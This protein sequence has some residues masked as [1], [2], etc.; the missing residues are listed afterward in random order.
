MSKIVLGKGLEALIP[1]D[2]LP[3]D[4]RNNFKILPL[5]R[6]A[7]NPMQPRR[8]FSEKGLEELAGS[9]KLNG[10]IQPLVVRKS[11]AS[12]TIIA[13]ERRYRAARLAELREVPVIVM[14]DVDDARM[15]EL[16]LV[17]NLQREDLNSL[18]VAEAYRMLI[19]RCGLTQN[20]LSERVGKSRTAVANLLRLLALPDSIK[21][22]IRDGRLSEGH[23]R[24]ILSVESETE[25]LK[26]A[27]QI[28]DQSLSVRLVE[29]EV[30]RKKRGKRLP[31]RKSP[32]I[33]EIE[34]WLKQL[35]GTSVKIHPGLKRGRIE[36]EYYNEDDLGRLVDLFKTIRN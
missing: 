20:Q 29:K 22:M 32:E 24:A 3:A 9:I 34:S 33:S 4:K 21:L 14:D 28:I 17:E 19:D 13:G 35:L 36:I 10:L 30:S 18:E 31:R 27:G 26:L 25:M 6:L 1:S 8:S 5:E 23:A 11:G 7:P 16:A 12:F 15:L 2:T